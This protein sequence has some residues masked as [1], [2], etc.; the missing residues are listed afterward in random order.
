MKA[1][2]GKWN[3]GDGCIWSVHGYGGLRISKRAAVTEDVF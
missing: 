2:V 1:I 3:V